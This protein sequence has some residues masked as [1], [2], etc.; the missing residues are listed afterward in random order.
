MLNLYL[1]FSSVL[2]VT[3]D[4]EHFLFNARVLKISNTDLRKKKLISRASRDFGKQHPMCLTVPEQ[5]P[6]KEHLKPFM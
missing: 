3:C 2:A 1:V 4:T 6:T 5:P